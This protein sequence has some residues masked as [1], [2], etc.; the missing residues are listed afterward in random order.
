MLSS[1][2]SERREREPGPIITGCGFAKGVYRFAPSIDHA[3]WVPA[4]AG[5]TAER[6]PIVSA[7]RPIALRSINSR[8]A[9]A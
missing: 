2:P 6:Y 7:T 5:T 9:F 4:F 1:R 3:V 8:I